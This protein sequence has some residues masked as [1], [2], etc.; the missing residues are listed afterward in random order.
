VRQRTEE[1]A[2]RPESQ[3][4]QVTFNNPGQ[5]ASERKAEEGEGDAEVGEKSARQEEVRLQADGGW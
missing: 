2:D 3:I 5:F 1:S 4:S